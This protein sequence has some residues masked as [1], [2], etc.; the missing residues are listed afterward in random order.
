MCIYTHRHTYIYT[1]TWTHI[2]THTFVYVCVC[3]YM[4]ICICVC[5]CIFFF[6]IIAT[7]VCVCV[8]DG[9]NAFGSCYMARVQREGMSLGVRM[10]SHLTECHLM[11]SMWFYSHSLDFLLRF[12]FLYLFA[13]IS[14]IDPGCFVNWSQCL[15]Q[16]C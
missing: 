9:F 7:S 2:H 8:C 1:D 6:T 13:P 15:S 14:S 16:K 3:L 5:A 11:L 10:K 12:S 4:C